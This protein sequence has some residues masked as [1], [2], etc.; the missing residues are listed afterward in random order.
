MGTKKPAS[1]NI[2]NKL[3]SHMD[4]RYFNKQAVVF[5]LLFGLV[6]TYF[7]IRVHAATPVAA[8][9]AESGTITAPASTGTSAAASGGSYVKFGA[10]SSYAGLHTCYP[11]AFCDSSNTVIKINGVNVRN[12]G[13]Y[14]AATICDNWADI[15]AHGFNAVRLAVNWPSTE[16]TEGTFNFTKLDDAVANAKANNMY[17]ILDAIHTTTVAGNNL[18][19]W[20]TGS[21]TMDKVSMGGP[22]YWQA[23][24]AHYKDDPNVIAYDLM[25]E[26]QPSGSTL[27]QDKAFS[28]YNTLINAVRAVDANKILIIEPVT[29]DSSLASANWSLITNK[30]NVVYS[31]H[32]YFAGGAASPYGSSGYASQG[33]AVY[34]G[35][36]GYTDNATNQTQMANHIT[37]ILNWLSTPRLPLY[38]GEFGI[39]ANATG[40]SEWITENVAIFNSNHLPRTYWEGCSQ[41]TMALYNNSTN[42]WVNYTNLFTTW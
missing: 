39:G 14:S 40:R 30:S 21:D 41:G 18:P 19:S 6:G 11:D 32:S 36:T 22:D 27:P 17:V 24:A 23:L 2:R 29:G 38:I 20:T 25:N 5:A 13:Q 33:V 9:E 12:V 28:M 15:K 10:G 1:R 37:T 3:R 26:P 35:V 31:A 42:V 7:M 16:P 8:T 34:D 4:T